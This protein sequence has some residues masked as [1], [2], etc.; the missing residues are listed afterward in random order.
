MPGRT[1]S[2]A[3]FPADDRLQ[4]LAG[5]LDSRFHGISGNHPEKDILWTGS[6]FEV[7]IGHTQAVRSMNR[8]PLPSSFIRSSRRSVA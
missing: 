8:S 2:V 1:V 5:I 3:P 7:N 4:V 6:A